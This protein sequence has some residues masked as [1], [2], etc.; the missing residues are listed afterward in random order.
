MHVN[1]PAAVED[2][3]QSDTHKTCENPVLSWITYLKACAA[4]N[5]NILCADEQT[6]KTFL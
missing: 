2:W 3:T 1:N 5:Q 4:Q 6:T